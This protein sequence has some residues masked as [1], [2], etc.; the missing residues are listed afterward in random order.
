MEGP[1]RRDLDMEVDVEIL[2]AERVHAEA[3]EG[4]GADRAIAAAMRIGG[5]ARCG[6]V[7]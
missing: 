6:E 5:G 7:H 2:D 4:R 1:L 3:E